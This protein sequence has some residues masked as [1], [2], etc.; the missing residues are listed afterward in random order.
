MLRESGGQV[1]TG[2]SRRILVR[3]EKYG[4][5]EGR[6][7]CSASVLGEPGT[8]ISRSSQV[9]KFMSG[10]C[11]L[12]TGMGQIVTPLPVTGGEAAGAH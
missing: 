3:G 6:K 7:S 10:V 9:Y 8:M 12:D 2:E 4:D 1:Q 5:A 11:A